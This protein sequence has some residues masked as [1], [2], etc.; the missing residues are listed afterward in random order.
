MADPLWLRNYDKG[1]PARIDYDELS[2]D[3]IF[4]RSAERFA[5]RPA[6]AFLNCEMS[7]AELSAEVD[8]AATAFT[9]LGLER[10]MRV[11]IQLPNCPQ[12][13]I[14]FLAALSCG[15]QVV[16]TNPLYTLREIEHQ[17]GDADCFLAVVADFIWDQTLRTGRERL[18]PKQYVIASIP[19]YLR[20]PLNL[21][22]PFKLRK[23]D[24][25][26][27]A[28]VLPE[29]GVHMFR[30]LV[31]S[32]ESNPPRPSI[33]MDDVAL[34]QYTGGTTGPSKGAMLTHR[35]LSCNVQQIDA[36][37]TGV[38][39]GEEVLLTCLPLFHVF[40]LTVCMGWGL[41]AGAKL[42]LVP[43][44]RD[45]KSL[46]KNITKHRV[47]LFPAVPALFN[48]LNNFPGIEK[49]DVSSIK[50]CFS[51]S[52]PLADEV[53]KRFEELT[54]SKIVEG[55][56]MS[57]TSPVATCNPLFGK[58]KV[59]S[60][61]IPVSDTEVKIVMAE[62][63]TRE[64]QP[65]QEGQLLIRGPQVMKGYLGREE[66]SA[67][68]LAGGWMHTGDLAVADEDGYLRIVGRMKDMINVNGMKVFPDEVDEVLMSHESILEAATI[69]LP[70][71]E[72]IERVKS[73]V[74]LQPGASLDAEAV[75][76]WCAENLARYKIPREVA[77]LDEL[78]KSSVMKILRREL[79]DMEKS[80]RGAD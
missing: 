13:V 16:M 39:H 11:A 57:E 36:W 30:K 2:L 66:A 40:G 32:S 44:P 10:G 33:D 27:I 41:W 3:A 70:D 62:D 60:V 49:Y 55:F 7:Y 20:F 79:R 6:L 51:G 8:R 29:P 23:E 78:P 28:K 64:V 61:G 50:C 69:G 24:P 38:V 43:N 46:V 17:W 45:F 80:A 37:F 75:Q 14:A 4:R 21:L 15:A 53:L 72:R 71:P 58:R 68:A 31:N 9:G 76:A 35:N 73:Y 56:G 52:A 34:L 63:E 42:V 12:A 48:G 5:D 26:K 19:E 65:G 67:E 59:G 77:F 25:P 22:A 74:V 47:T 1:V 18:A 54:G